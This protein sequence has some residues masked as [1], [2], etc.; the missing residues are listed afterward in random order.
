MLTWTLLL[1]TQC[2]DLCHFR[3]SQKP[4]VDLG[5]QGHVS[6]VEALLT[7]WPQICSAVAQLF[8]SYTCLY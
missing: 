5:S 7:R 2:R 3:A 4:N 1:V 8:R 6:V